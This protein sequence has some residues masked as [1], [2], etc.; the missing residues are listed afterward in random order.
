VKQIPSRIRQTLLALVFLASSFPAFGFDAT[1]RLTNVPIQ[2][3]DVGTALSQ[4]L[5]QDFDRVFPTKSYGVRVIVD[6]LQIGNG[7]EVVYISVGLAR[8]LPDGR[9]LQQHANYSYA[10]MLPANENQGKKR[11]EILRTL[12]QVANK[13]SQAV[14]EN[15]SRVR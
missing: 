6:G 1:T 5:T 7:Q 10:L 11:D 15:Q 14:I 13:F 2:D 9:H 8:R 12:S 3:R 4:G